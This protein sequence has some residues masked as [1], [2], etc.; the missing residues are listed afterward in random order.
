M[1]TFYPAASTQGISSYLEAMAA[2]RLGVSR[3]QGSVEHF[4]SSSHAVGGFGNGAGGTGASIGA[5]GIQGGVWRLSGG[6]DGGGISYIYYS[7][8]Q[9]ATSV[10]SKWHLYARAAMVTAPQANTKASILALANGASRDITLGVYGSSITGGSATKFT[11]CHDGASGPAAARVGIST[12]SIDT[13]WHEFEMWSDGTKVRIS[14][15]KEAPILTTA[16]NT[17]DVRQ[18]YCGVTGNTGGTD[19]FDIDVLAI[20]MPEA[21]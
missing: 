14:V 3:M 16:T 9:M 4:L 19:I 7:G 5:R 2:A 10:T 13:G 18:L 15:D 1:E 12:V 8:V 11:A 21:A 17:A 6:T 20:H